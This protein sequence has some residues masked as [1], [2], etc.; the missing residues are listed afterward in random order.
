MSI[1]GI[2]AGFHYAAATVIN[3]RKD[4]DRFE[5]LYGVKVLS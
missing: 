2:S 5:Q 4:A 3:D 1:L